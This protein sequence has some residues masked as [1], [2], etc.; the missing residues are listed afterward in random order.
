MVSDGAILK[1]QATILG[2]SLSRIEEISLDNNYIND[3]GATVLKSMA[4][5]NPNILKVDIKRNC[6]GQYILRELARVLK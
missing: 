3:K 4:Q 2:A 5:L 6:A 1:H